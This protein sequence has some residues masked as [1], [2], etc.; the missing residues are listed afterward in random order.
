MNLAVAQG[1]HF[2]G[3]RTIEWSTKSELKS[4][5]NILNIDSDGN[6]NDFSNFDKLE[7]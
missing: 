6:S 1:S 4:I 3:V 7:K 5:R 2:N